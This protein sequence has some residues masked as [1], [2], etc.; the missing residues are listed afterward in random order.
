MCSCW[1][2]CDS[3]FCGVLLCDLLLGVKQ[4]LLQMLKW[5]LNTS[6]KVRV[7]APAHDI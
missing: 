3:P 1:S 4:A 6:V 2:R 5:D 7:I